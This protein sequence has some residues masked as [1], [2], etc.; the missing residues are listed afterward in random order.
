MIGSSS[1]DVSTLPR[2]PRVKIVDLFRNA[3]RDEKR[4]ENCQGNKLCPRGS[5]LRCQT[6]AIHYLLRTGL[7]TLFHI[8]QT[9]RSLILTSGISISNIKDNFFSEVYDDKAERIFFR[10]CLCSTIM[11]LAL[12]LWRCYACTIR[13]RSYSLSLVGLH[14]RSIISIL[15]KDIFASIVFHPHQII[16]VRNFI[17]LNRTTMRRKCK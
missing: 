10:I 13:D 14:A 1:S 5:L 3:T 8:H 7:E 12:C 11:L 15:R 17:V 6:R 2:L 4:R 9:D 16:F